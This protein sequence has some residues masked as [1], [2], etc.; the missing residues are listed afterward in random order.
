VKYWTDLGADPNLFGENDP[1]IAGLFD[2]DSFVVDLSLS[3]F[4]DPNLRFNGSQAELIKTSG[5]L[6]WNSMVG[7]YGANGLQAF[8]L[9]PLPVYPYDGMPTYLPAY[10]RAIEVIK[11]SGKPYYSPGLVFLLEGALWNSNI[12]AWPNIA[13]LDFT[14][15]Y[16]EYLIVTI[17]VNNGVSSDV[18][19][20]PI[21]VVNYPVENFPPVLQLG[22]EDQTFYVGEVN[23]YHINFIDPDCFIFCMSPEPKTSHVPGYPISEDFR[24]DMDD[25][26]WGLSLNYI[27]RY[28]Y[29]PWIEDRPPDRSI[30]LYT[31]LIRWVPEFKGVYEAIVTCSDA[32]GGTTYGEMTIE[33]I[34][35]PQKNTYYQ[36]P[37]PPALYLLPFLT[38]SSLVSTGSTVYQPYGLPGT[39]D[40][41][42][43]GLFGHV[44]IP[45]LDSLKMMYLPSFPLLNRGVSGIQEFF[46]IGT[47]KASNGTDR[48]T[49]D[50][51]W[52]AY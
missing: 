25:L 18:R 28:D 44:Y 27:D 50:M 37:I 3:V 16:F 2:M 13:A 41:Q 10:F 45:P 22:I 34:Y 36:I 31:G 14:P 46:H 48:L 9:Q 11:T 5:T 23:E 1:N 17:E 26:C 40:Y 21:S 43:Y 19:T 35:P 39:M 24:T 49:G 30:N 29:G 32:R 47:L 52:W 15:Q 51:P 38:G 20:F 7:G 4:A 6:D 33:C 12:T 8:L 42:S